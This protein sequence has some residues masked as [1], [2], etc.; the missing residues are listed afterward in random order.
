MKALSCFARA[1][2]GPTLVGAGMVVVM[3][4]MIDLSFA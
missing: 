2:G 3:V 1:G 4:L